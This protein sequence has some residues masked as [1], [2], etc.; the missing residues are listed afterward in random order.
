KSFPT[1]LTF[2]ELL[3][4]MD[5]LMFTQRRTVEEDF[6]ADTTL[7]TLTHCVDSQLF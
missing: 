1:F 3:S 4:S 5:S 2:I 7:V 6:P